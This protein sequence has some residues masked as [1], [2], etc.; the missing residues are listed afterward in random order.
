MARPR[1]LLALL[2]GLLL[3]SLAPGS[4]A[5][6]TPPDTTGFGAR[7]N[8]LG[9]A[10]TADVDDG[11]ANYFNPA[12]LARAEG[13]T[14]GLGYFS[15][16]SRLS[17]EGSD[18]EVERIGGLE[19]GVAAPASFGWLKIAFG[20]GLQLPDQRLSRTRSAV[21]ERPRWEMYDTRPH[22]VFLAANL[23]LRLFDWLYLGGGII[24]QSPSQMYVEIRGDADIVSPER[25]THLEHQFKGDLISQRYPIFGA[26]LRASDWLSVGLTYRGSVTLDNGVQAIIDGHFTGLG[27]PI[28][29]DFYLQ[30]LALGL[31]APQQLALG[32]ALRPSPRLRLGVD[33]TWIDWSGHGSLIS[34]DEV[35]LDVAVP[36]GVDLSIPDRIVGRSAI[37]LGLSDTLVTRLGAEYALHDSEVY[38]L[39]LRGGYVYQPTPFPAQTGITNF[40][41]SDRHIFTLGAGLALRDLEPTVAGELR[42]EGSLMLA[43]LPERMHQKRSLVDPV[44][45]YRGGGWQFGFNLGVGLA[46]R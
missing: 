34:R 26:Q 39:D 36:P 32:I 25:R 23:G 35:R 8:A 37:P 13:L 15:L 42:L 18:S 7:A 1:V 14:L 11:A 21:P 12:G 31:F 24:F 19:L 9:G 3:G 10:V 44:G 38:G 16:H 30:S 46:F 45:D 6:A 27:D 28:P 29:V 20:L 17:I 40:V 33:L 22:R 5:R 43:L 41:D 2:G 4:L